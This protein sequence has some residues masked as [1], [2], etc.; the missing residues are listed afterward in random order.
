MSLATTSPKPTEFEM[1]NLFELTPDLVCIAGKDGILKKVNPAVVQK[2][3]Y[4]AAEL[5]SRPIATLIYPEDR[6]M[7]GQKR[8]KLLNGEAL[9]N[10]QNRYIK[11]DGAIIWLEWTSIY[12]ADKE[13]VFAIA[14]D[15]T[16]RKQQ[17][18]EIEDKYKKFKG[19]ATHFKKSI[20]QDRKFLAVELHEE[21]AQL[22]TVAKMD[23]QWLK[24]GLT[25]T[26]VVFTNRME[27]AL[28]ISELL[29][30]TIRRISFSISPGMLD[31][32]GLNEVLKWQCREFS[33]LNG[34]PCKF[35]SDFDE[36]VL[37]NEVKLDFFRVCQESLSNIMYHAEATRVVISIKDEDD[38]VCLS[39]TDDGKGFD[40]AQQKLSS[41]LTHIREVTT[42]I[43]GELS[44]HSEQGKGTRICVAI[45]KS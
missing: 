40:P 45:A 25:D 4:T 18:K 8:Q 42:S 20:E 21:L 35:E 12:I 43:N 13:I 1:F 15:I 27:H 16:L 36:T 5:Y 22:A 19:L 17:E 14:K 29:I 44:I 30:N 38:K 33:V 24:D 2:L 31:D 37:T 41:G 10:F 26:S 39:I 11:K 32:L 7:T 28:M 23:I 6:E 3:G 34:I 9:L